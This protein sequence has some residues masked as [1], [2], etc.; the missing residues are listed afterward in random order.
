FFSSRRRHTRFSRDWSSD[1]CSSDL[2]NYTQIPLGF[3]YSGRAWLYLGLQYF[4]NSPRQLRYSRQPGRALHHHYH[5]RRAPDRIP[6]NNGQGFWTSYSGRWRRILSP[7]PLR[8]FA[9]VVRTREP[10]PKQTADFLSAPLGDRPRT[11][12][13]SQCK[14][15]QQFPS[16]H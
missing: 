14:L 7:V 11:A 1:V 10:R 16:L 13:R 8:T 12:A 15:V 9:L 3:G 4:S 2:F 6:A 5:Q